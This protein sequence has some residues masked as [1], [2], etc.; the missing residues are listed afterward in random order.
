MAHT[1]ISP[2]C[3]YG[4]AG[5]AAQRLL[6]DL[7]AYNNYYSSR[8]GQYAADLTYADKRSQAS[9]EWKALTRDDKAI[10]YEGKP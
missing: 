1:R 9:T 5:W 10:F 2:I 7:K 6:G 4:K 8:K 3:E